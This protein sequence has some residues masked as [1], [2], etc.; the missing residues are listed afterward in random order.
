[1][2]L[3]LPRQ[4]IVEDEDANG[5]KGSMAAQT[6]FAGTPAKLGANAFTRKGWVFI[7]WS[8]S[9]N[10]PVAYKDG[11]SVK[12]LVAS[13]KAATLYAAWAKAS[14]KVK[15]Y[16]NDGSGRTAVQAF[17]Y[18][19]KK[20]LKTNTFKRDGYTFAGWAKSKAKAKAGKVAYKNKKAVK[21]LVKNGKTVKLYAVWKKK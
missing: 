11:Q 12:D 5:G 21:D 4:E 14:Y 1:M 20:K 10:G 16:A 15:F 19:K 18:G 2:K 13:G 9:R 8:T 6:M 3:E 7:G 17:R